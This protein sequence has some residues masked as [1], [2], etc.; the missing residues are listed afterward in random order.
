MSYRLRNW[1]LW[2]FTSALLVL[3]LFTA[4]R[5]LQP[6]LPAA[7]VFVAACLSATISNAKQLIGRHKVGLIVLS[8]LVTTGA[9]SVKTYQEQHAKRATQARLDLFRAAVATLPP[10]TV[11]QPALALHLSLSMR[12]AFGERNYELVDD[13]A[14]VLSGIDPN[15]GAALYFSGEVD[16][17]RGD[18]ELMRGHFLRYLALADRVEDSQTGEAEDCYARGNG[19]CGE[20]TGWIAHLLANDLVNRGQPELA[21]PLVAR[22]RRV[23]PAGFL[24]TQTQRSTVELERMVGAGVVSNARPP[25]GT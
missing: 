16:R 10:N 24:P 7:A 3:A 8:I 21:R 6:W 18:L 22:E 25:T 15:N 13:L 23:F 17:M 19:Y 4:S 5:G 9:A 2:V 11:Q 12:K 14:A 20:R 1:V